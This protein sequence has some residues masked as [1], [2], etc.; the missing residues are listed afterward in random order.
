MTTLSSKL[1]ALTAL[2]AVGALMPSGADAAIL[3]SSNGA[4]VLTKDGECVITNWEGSEGC[5]AAKAAAGLVGTAVPSAPVVEQD[6]AVHFGFNSSKLTQHAIHQLDRQVHYLRQADVKS[7]TIVGY[8]DRVG[9]AAYNEKLSLKRAEAVRAYLVSKGV[10]AKKLHVVSKGK[11]QPKADCSA[12]LSH[13]KLVQCLH[14]DRRVE[15]QV[16]EAK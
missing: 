7:V 15:L 6:K 11:T 8:A 3:Y 2:L 14:E 9:N 4:P 13:A 16:N 12:D 5:D 1:L 10:S